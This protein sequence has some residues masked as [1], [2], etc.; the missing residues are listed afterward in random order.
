[1]VT[2]LEYRLHSLGEVYGG[3]LMHPLE[4]APEVF[5]FLRDFTAQAPDELTVMA[6]VIS[7]PEGQPLSALAAYRAAR[8][9]PP[10]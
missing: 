5:A 9:A 8:A 7:S 10:D 3:A 4:R 1:V 2:S 6:A